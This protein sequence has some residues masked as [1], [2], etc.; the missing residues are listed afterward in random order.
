MNEVLFGGGDF[1]KLSDDDL[2]LW[3]KVPVDAEL[4]HC[5]RWWGSYGYSN[6]EAKRPLKSE[7]A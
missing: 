1:K 2:A 5:S 6:G 7:L 4:M 3:L